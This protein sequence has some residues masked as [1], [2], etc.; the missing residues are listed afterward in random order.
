MIDKD[1]LG[2]RSDDGGFV[3]EDEY[4]EYVKAHKA[5]YP[6]EPRVSLEIHLNYRHI[7]EGKRDDPCLCPLALAIKDALECN[8]CEVWRDEIIID[9]QTYE[10]TE[11]MKKFIDY[12]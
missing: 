1:N 12:F 6:D 8:E 5:Q 11:E 3:P 10:T 4:R 2:F 9:R 7:Y